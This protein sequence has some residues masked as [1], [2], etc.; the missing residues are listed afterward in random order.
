VSARQSVEQRAE[1]AVVFTARGLSFRYPHAAANAVTGVDLDVATGEILALLGPNG[2]GKSTLLRL[3][4]GAL[5]P[6]EGTVLLS[7]RALD[8]WRREDIARAVG[9][10]TQAEELAFPITVRE[11][12]AM[13]RYP[14]LGAWRREGAA[15]R[16]AIARALDR[17]RLTDL[18]ARSVL[19]L[20]GGERQR[21]RVARALAQ[22][23][24]TLLLDEPTA[25]LDIA[26]EMSLFELLS[27]LRRDGVTVVIVTHNI[28]VAA[29]YADRLVMLDRGRI[30]A[31]GSPDHVLTRDTVQ[32]VYHWP[33]DIT[34]ADNA[35]QVLPRRANPTHERSDS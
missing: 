9:V 17:C 28:N 8:E 31:T 6:A 4:L 16:E 22:E 24:R 10:V 27:E 3:L 15:D 23:P 11:M 1:A 5:R 7:G 2:S 12:T 33:V 14:Y 26:H 18:A 34:R 20:S 32:S 29:R 19:E 13:G 21:A 25:S 35:P 30:A